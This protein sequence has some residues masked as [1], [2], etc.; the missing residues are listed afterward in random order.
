[1][2]MHVDGKFLVNPFVS[3]FGKEQRLYHGPVKCMHTYSCMCVVHDS[4]QMS[5][6]ISNKLETNWQLSLTQH[7]MR[8]KKV[9]R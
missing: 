1:M 2:Y 8:E 6:S 9:I 3:R 4:C 7:P 5:V